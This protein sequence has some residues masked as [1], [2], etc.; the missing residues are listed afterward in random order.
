MFCSGRSVWLS[1]EVPASIE[2]EISTD[3]GARMSTAKDRKRVYGGVS[4]QRAARVVPG[5]APPV[6]G[7]AAHADFKYNGGAVIRAP[8]VFTSFWGSQW[9]DAAHT[10]RANRL[11]QFAQDLLSSNY[12]NVLS[13]YGVGSGAGP[14]GT[15]VKATF[16]P[17]SPRQLD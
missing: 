3:R 1:G 8:Q 16:A 14:S 4:P 11:N 2:P 13:Q 9:S 10:T 15:F 7:A 6:P 5:A 12:M 17:N